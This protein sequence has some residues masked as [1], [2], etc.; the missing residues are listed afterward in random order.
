VDEHREP[1][2]AVGASSGDVPYPLGGQCSRKDVRTGQL[3]DGP[4]E[5]RK[6]DIEA[7]KATIPFRGKIGRLSYQ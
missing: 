5:K 1:R 7:V 2:E 6:P 3:L 4:K